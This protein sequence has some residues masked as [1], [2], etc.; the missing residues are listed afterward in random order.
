MYLNS[1][2]QA[3]VIMVCEKHA[4]A[5]LSKLSDCP[6]GNWFALPAVSVCR[7]GYR[8]NVSAP[9]PGQGC[10]VFGFAESVALTRMLQEFVPVNEDGSVCPDCAAYEW[11]ITPTAM[12]ESTHDPV[13]G[14][15]VDCVNSLSHN[16]N[17]ELF[18]FCSTGCRD[19]FRQEPLRYA[20]LNQKPIVTQ[21]NVA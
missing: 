15:R 16:Y 10:A 19:A 20:R 3:V 5:L 12:V 11:N 1:T 2:M 14:R 13:C 18:F 17:G 9:H 6:E 4:S 7:T 8:P 21:E